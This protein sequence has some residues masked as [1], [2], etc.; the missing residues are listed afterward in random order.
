MKLKSNIIWAAALSLVLGCACNK[1]KTKVEEVEETTTE[2]PKQLPNGAITFDYA[3]HLYFDVM[4]HDTL[5]ARMAFD[6]GNT[7]I[8]FDLE[9]YNQHF[10]PANNLHRTIIQGAGNS[11][12]GAYRDNR[13]WTYTIG[14]QSH[15]EQGATVLN[16]RKILGN[17]VDGMFGMEF[18]R[19]RKVEVNYA[20]GYMLLLNQ[21]QQPTEGYT[22]I[23]CK[24]LNERKSRLLMPLSTTFQD[25]TSLKGYF[26][27]DLGAG[28]GVVFNSS[29]TTKVNIRTALK[30]VKKKLFD[31]GG[32]GGSRTDYIFKTRSVSVGGNTI[33]NAIA[34]YSGNTQ[35]AM[36]D[37]RY[38]GIIGNALLEHF[39]VI[40]DFQKGEIWLR[41]NANFEASAEFDS[42]ITLTPQSDC[43]VVN[44]LIEGGNAHRAGI[45]RGDVIVSINDLTP[46]QVN[47][48]HLKKMNSSASDWTVVVK[49]DNTTEKITFKKEKM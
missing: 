37:S 38:D 19:N 43:W 47:H 28:D 27:V 8:L 26:L 17:N 14:G 33:E 49:R 18:M 15:T 21:E 24:W 23:E 34:T 2:T 20:D 30:D 46:E 36:A 40:F 44:G 35:G 31:T 29:L 32:V 7:N 1:T 22:R 42:G 12:Q 16:L 45:K 39:D 6:T 9:F 13:D 48:K 4:L 11:L 10:D 25:G 3:R 41:P 5:P